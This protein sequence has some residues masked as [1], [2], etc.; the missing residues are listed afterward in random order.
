M[1]QASASPSSGSSSHQMATESPME[2]TTRPVLTVPWFGPLG[3]GQYATD[4]PICGFSPYCRRASEP[5]ELRRRITQPFS[6]DHPAISV[7]VGHDDPSSD[8]SAD[9]LL[10]H[11]QHLGR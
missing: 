4:D 3:S 11:V 8:V 9:L 1:D 2:S 5:S 7:L 10:V 6:M